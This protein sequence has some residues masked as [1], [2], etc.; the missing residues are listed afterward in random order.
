LTTG[1][2]EGRVTAENVAISN[3][4]VV[5]EGAHLIGKTRNTV[6]TATGQF[7]FL[8]LDPGQYQLVINH[9]HFEKVQHQVTIIMDRVTRHNILMT[10]V[11]EEMEITVLA[12]PA[13]KGGSAP[14][15]VINAEEL[16]TMPLQNNRYQD[17]LPLLPE[18]TGDSD[19]GFHSIGSRN[20]QIS[21]L[22]DGEN[23]TDPVT[24]TFGFNIPLDAVASM[25]VSSFG[26]S[27]EYGQGQGGIINLVTGS[28]TNE[29]TGSFYS[30]APVLDYDGLDIM[31]IQSWNPGFQ[32]SG[33]LFNDLF[34]LNFAFEYRWSE[35]RVEELPPGENRSQR[36]GYD[37]FIG[38]QFRHRAR[39]FIKITAVTFPLWINDRYL[40]F[41]RPQETTVNYTQNGYA[42]SMMVRS[43][44]NPT[45]SLESRFKYHHIYLMSHPQGGD[46][47]EVHPA[48]YQ[49]NYYNDQERWSNRPGIG[50]ILSKHISW[51]GLHNI[52][53]GFQI[54]R[55]D[56]L[57]YYANND[58]L[59]YNKDKELYQSYSYRGPTEF[60]HHRNHYAFFIQ[61][62]HELSPRITIY[63]G[64]RMDHDQAFNNTDW[65]PRT[66]VLFKPFSRNSTIIRAGWGRFYDEIPLQAAAYEDFPTQYETL[67]DEET[68]EIIQQPSPTV[69][70][71]DRSLRTPY[72]DQWYIL[73]EQRW[74]PTLKT[75]VRYLTKQ[76]F[77]ELQDISIIEPD[78]EEY[79]DQ[80]LM[81]TNANRS[82]YHSVTLGLDLSLFR[83]AY[84]SLSYTW[85][86]AYGDGA[87]WI[88]AEGDSPDPKQREKEWAPLPWDTPHRLISQFRVPLFWKM[89]MNAILEY[90]TGYPYSI[91][92]E[93]QEI[94]GSKN[95][96][97]FPDYFRL[98][99]LV[100]RRFPFSKKFDV[101]AQG[102]AVNLTN[103]N[104]PEYI[105]NNMDAQDFGHF[106][107][108][109]DISLQLQLRLVPNKQK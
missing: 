3:V 105:Q 69:T 23:T 60:S 91:V 48:G 42:L 29:W 76:G 89:N 49:G 83:Q 68:G 88:T 98:D 10:P 106:Y 87:D 26:Y 95:S 2:L 103:H 12:E 5:L 25:E 28:G 47:F 75:M 14:G 13:Q 36:Q 9:P 22:I 17:I 85:S 44:L 70:I 96:H 32:V 53:T 86:S 90:R 104:N 73:W 92:N 65:A 63:A 108:S 37:A 102:G 40:A 79:I 82:E 94:T 1:S 7:R 71:L 66:G 24:G 72:G 45:L 51:A 18:I 31:G 97:R 100:A 59:Y 84:L 54:E 52:R 19:S 43:I 57:Q 16:D 50:V 4:S 58:I 78:E 99:V 38:L 61:D 80:K 107:G 67:F 34:R 56:Y 77:Q 55:T 33:P 20:R 109:D 6:T 30:F 8:G 39:H 21:F 46:P 35:N 81:L 11:G 64:L 74:W 27:A 62:D 93:K 101:L 41:N 15:T